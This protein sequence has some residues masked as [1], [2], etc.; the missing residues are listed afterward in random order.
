MAKRVTKKISGVQ[1]SKAAVSTTANVKRSIS[2]R[3]RNLQTSIKNI[4]A[5]PAARYVA[6]GLGLAVLAR[7]AMKYYKSHP[8]ISEYVKENFDTVEG[9]LREY[10]SSLSSS[11]SNISEDAAQ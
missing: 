3:G 9:K 6:G 7:F 1:H 2:L 4:A 10:R 5:M 8:A 11:D